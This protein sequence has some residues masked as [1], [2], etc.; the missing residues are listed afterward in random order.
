MTSR[1][2]LLSAFGACQEYSYDKAIHSVNHWPLGCASSSKRFEVL[3]ASSMMT[4]AAFKLFS[5]ATVVVKCLLRPFLN[6]FF[7]QFLCLL[8]EKINCIHYKLSTVGGAHGR[9]HRK[10]LCMLVYV[11]H[12]VKKEQACRLRI[13]C[14]KLWVCS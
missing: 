12:G 4:H 11:F 2:Q 13:Y 1:V 14:G 3:V 8:I 5:T 7:S 9:T 10:L 6:P